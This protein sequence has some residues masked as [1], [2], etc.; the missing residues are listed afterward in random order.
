MHRESISSSEYD[1][2]YIL[3]IGYEVA[4]TTLGKGIW[5]S[6]EVGGKSV[7]EDGWA[8]DA[9]SVYEWSS[10]VS[11]Y[12]WW[13]GGVRAV[14]AVGVDCDCVATGRLAITS[15]C[16]KGIWWVGGTSSYTVAVG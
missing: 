8:R 3:Y 6:C 4:E 1:I 15:K 2:I 13:R 7:C 10:L 16:G 5:K 12:D 14:R 9:N 11:N